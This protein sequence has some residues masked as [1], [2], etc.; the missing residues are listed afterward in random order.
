MVQRIGAGRPVA[1]VA[2]EMGVSRATAWR[3]WRR[4][5]AEGAARLE[6]RP[7]VANRQPGRTAPCLDARIRVLR[8]LAWRG[9]VW[10]GHRLGVPAS[11]VGRVLA[12]HGTAMLRECDPVTDQ[13][14]R[15]SHRLANRYEHP[16]PGSPVHADVN[17]LGRIPDRGGWRAHGRSEQVRG[18][19]SGYDRAQALGITLCTR[20]HCP[21]TNGKAEQFNR[22]MASEWADSSVR[23]PPSRPRAHLARGRQ[24]ERTPPRHPRP[25]PHRPRYT[26]PRVSR[27]GARPCRFLLTTR[28]SHRRTRSV[29]RR[30]QRHPHQRAARA[31]GDSRPERAR[32]LLGR[33][34]AR[35][36]AA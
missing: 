11:T 22:T 3:W 29:E 28:A 16:Y 8:A 15:A 5:R 35:Q 2:A 25:T 14:D 1:H 24:R 33:S 10:I 31:F 13:L 20:P 6:D 4:W 9:P 21:W 27:P 23:R 32:P 17:T 19:G 26:T 7:S 18:R 12:R 34:S 30:R 36:L